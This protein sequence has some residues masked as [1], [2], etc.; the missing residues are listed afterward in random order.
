MIY[1][2]V[3]YL[4]TQFPSYVFLANGFSQ[5]SAKDSIMLSESGGE[6]QHW[7]SRTNHAVQIISRATIVNIAKKQ[8]DDIYEELKN[9][10]GLTLPQVIIDG[11]TYEQ[12]RTY[13]I[14]PV[15]SPSYLGANEEHLEMFSFNLTIVTK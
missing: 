2:L 11:N 12:V 13:Q 14:S 5:D 4:I 1:N 3:Q 6:P 15:Q 8:I 9:R 10:F 7:Y